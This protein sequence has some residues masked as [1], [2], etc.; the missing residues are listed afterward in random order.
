[1]IDR[2]QQER[3][4]PFPLLSP[5]SSHTHPSR[6]GPLSDRTCWF[7]LLQELSA[8]H[9]LF[10]FS[11]PAASW[12]FALTHVILHIRRRRWKEIFRLSN[13]ILS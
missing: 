9:T 4:V 13:A 11:V 5:P 2:T 12:A 10:H 1:M 7:A 8:S 6:S 3:P